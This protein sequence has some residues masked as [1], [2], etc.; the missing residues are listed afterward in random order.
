MD[1]SSDESSYPILALIVWQR[2]MRC[3][4]T[5]ASSGIGETIARRLAV[6][7]YLV[8][9]MARRL[10]RVRKIATE[11]GG[12]IAM[13]GDVGSVEDYGVVVHRVV[14]TFGGLDTLVNAAGTWV[15]D[16]LHAATYE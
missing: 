1:G 16:P 7:G 8:A 2:C 15:E 4:I 5:G 12:A 13:L 10:A 6:E 3:L 9:L 11:L 14:K